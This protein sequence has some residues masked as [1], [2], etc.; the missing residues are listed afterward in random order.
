MSQGEQ[1]VA[2]NPSDKLWWV[3]YLQ[4]YITNNT[5]V[6]FE[7]YRQTFFDNETSSSVQNKWTRRESKEDWKLR[8][9]SAIRRPFESAVLEQ[10]QR[11]VTPSQMREAQWDAEANQAGPTKNEQREAYKSL[12]GRKPKNKGVRGEN[13]AKINARDESGYIST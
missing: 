5:L 9:K 12:G 8:Y 4:A 7:I 11:S 13:T 1:K 10:I 2:Q 3:N 6:W